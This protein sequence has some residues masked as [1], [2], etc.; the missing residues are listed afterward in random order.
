MNY[1]IST[2]KFS[3]FAQELNFCMKNTNR[4]WVCRNLHLTIDFCITIPNFAWLYKNG[5][6]RT[7]NSNYLHA[8]LFILHIHMKSLLVRIQISWEFLFHSPVYTFFCI[9]VFFSIHFLFVQIWQNQFNFRGFCLNMI[10]NLSK[11]L[12]FCHCHF[13][14]I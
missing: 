9:M 6:R 10:F 8:F 12:S 2:Q 5:C 7:F 4:I 14:K 1:R 13:A 11:S 3:I